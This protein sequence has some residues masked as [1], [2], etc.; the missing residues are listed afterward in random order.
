VL[1]A[2]HVAL[3]EQLVLNIR[4]AH[5]EALSRSHIIQALVEAAMRRG[6]D[7]AQWV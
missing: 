2:R 3:L 4:M 5:G 1:F 6:I 7:A